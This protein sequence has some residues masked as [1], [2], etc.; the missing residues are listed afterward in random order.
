MIS[1]DEAIGLVL[2]HARPSPPRRLPATEALGLV[3]AE[4]IASD[5]D[6]PP[7]E[8]SL[9]DG[10]AL[11][12]DDFARGRT[13][14]V[15][16]E[17]IVA[18]DVPRRP[19]GA[20]E[21]SEIMTGAPLPPGAD[22]VVM[23]EHV[24]RADPAAIGE[25]NDRVRI[26]EQS[27]RPGQNV[28]PRAA[29]FARGQILLRAGHEL[30]PIELGLLA[31][32]GRGEV[33]VIPRPTVAVLA[34]GNELVPPSCRPGP[35]Q[36]RNSNTSLLLAAA[37]RAGALGVD[38]GISRDEPDALARLLGEALAADVVLVSGGVSA[39]V[40]DLVPAVLARLGVEQVFHRVRVRPGKP[41]WFGV[42]PASSP[43]ANGVAKLVFGLPGN[44]VSGLVTFE[45][46]VR[47][48][49]ARLAGRSDIVRPTTRARLACDHVHRGD[50][51]TFH[52]ARL[53]GADGD[54]TVRPLAWR[55]SGDLAALVEANAL[56]S[57]AAG[58]Y[59]LPK[60]ATIDVLPL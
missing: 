47:P 25:R 46:F 14:L 34:T 26:A 1:V 19:L 16:V 57:L 50:R 37:V 48:A 21:T 38:L 30:R 31:E 4:E 40:L 23:L 60:G 10:Y 52:P 28:M 6:S 36:I 29:S 51:P 17:Q 33:M 22:A 56:A 43:A 7:H 55:G 44:P 41:L 3:L 24:V 39:G 2:A 18:G 49:L 59:S 54:R 9:V 13:G 12:S 5:V 42:S 32:V 45:L 8:K 15:V 58:D 35:G 53:E 27:V 20:G 11:S